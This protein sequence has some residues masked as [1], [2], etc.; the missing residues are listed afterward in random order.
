VY[1]ALDACG[2]ITEDYYVVMGK[3]RIDIVCALDTLGLWRWLTDA[4]IE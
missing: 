2:K 4:V 1:I 3:K